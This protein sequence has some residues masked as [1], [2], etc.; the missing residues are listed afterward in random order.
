MAGESN[1]APSGAPAAQDGP[2][3]AAAAPNQ[4]AG[5]ANTEKLTAAQL[6]AK[7]K[8]EKAARRAQVK[9]AR[10]AAA[11]APP[12]QEKGAAGAD[13]KG[14]KGKGKQE[15][16]QTQSRGAHRPSIS[17]RRPSMPAVE[18]D[19][20]SG[21]P[22]CFSHVPMAKRIPT[23][24][25]HKDVH[26]AVLAVGQKMATFALQDSISRLRATLLAF[27]KV[28]ALYRLNHATS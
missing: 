19:V 8:A 7:A 11:P 21:I 2:K 27:R 24:Q 20:R 23:T 25:A 12:T 10:T 22:D 9:E 15:G 14:A 13:A 17:G 3:G 16:Q 26:P 18:K 28:G 6:K 5:P 4:T 1:G